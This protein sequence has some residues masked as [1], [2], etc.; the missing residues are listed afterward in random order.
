LELPPAMNPAVS[1]QPSLTR[2]AIL[3]SL[4]LVGLT[5]AAYAPALRNG[6][7]WDDQQYV[8]DNPRVLGGLNPSNVRWA[9]TTLYAC[10]WHPLTWMSL[11]LDA[12]FGAGAA[13]YHLTNI[14]LHCANVVL[15]FLV[16]LQ[17]TNTL[18]QSAFVAGLFA[19][20]PLH[21]ES[22]AWITERKDV[23]SALFWMLT[24][25]A[26]VQYVR[27]PGW[28]RYFLVACMLG[29][30]LLAKQML[31]TLPCVLLLLDFWPLGRWDKECASP[32]S[33]KGTS[34]ASGLRRLSFW[35]LLAE[36]VPLFLMVAVTSG[37]TIMAQQN[38]MGSLEHIPPLAR[39]F[40]ALWSYVAYVGLMIWPVSLSPFYPHPALLPPSSPE[41][42]RLPFLAAGA[43]LGLVAVSAIVVKQNRKRPYLAFGWLWF[44]GTLVPVIGIVQVGIQ[45]HADRYTYIP[46]I[47][48][49]VIISWG[50]AELAGRWLIPRGIQAVL[51]G[52]ALLA[53]LLLT[54]AQLSFWHDNIVFWQRAARATPDNVLALESLG[55]ALG[56]ENRLE[57][58]VHSFRESLR[59]NPAFVEAHF[60]LG[61]ALEKQGK[62]AEAFNEYQTAVGLRPGYV[63]A[64]HKL[65]VMFERQQ[66]FK[67]AKARYEEALKVDPGDPDVL[68]NMGILIAREG[69]PASAILLFER[70]LQTKPN[71]AHAHLNLGVALEQL[72]KLPEAADQFEQATLADPASAM[73]FNH[74][75]MVLRQLGQPSPALQ[76][77]Q[78]AVRLEPNEVRFR[79]NLA[80]FLKEVGRSDE[81]ARQFDQVLRQEPRWCE[82]VNP[83][84]WYLATAP[85]RENRDGVMAMILAEEICQRTGA[86]DARFLDTLAAAYAEMGRFPQAIQ[87]IQTALKAAKPEMARQMQERLRLYQEGKPFRSPQG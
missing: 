65:G 30:G 74:W 16:F 66:N 81:A 15:L 61:V 40:N 25:L 64:L 3:L 4:A 53:C 76:K 50:G 47:G 5:V 8:T 54:R 27:R 31:V 9:W 10:N 6:F 67:E 22:V 1:S 55:M 20:H 33:N 7:V 68:T 83:S 69:N 17:M 23:L 42:L 63:H 39:V 38:A 78:E 56:A 70:A 2:N 79:T 35:R 41:R 37:M 82:L 13:G 44:L 43:A 60:N 86:K 62:F 80:A 71:H 12:Q 21:V 45:A 52:G 75:G 11:Q 51:A 59:I 77:L 72:G 36:K 19:V 18:G 29:L 58:A 73:A 24:L 28:A 26:Y 34:V 14:L 85:Q 46:L 48:L 84:A 32:R 57:E 87:T 49:Y